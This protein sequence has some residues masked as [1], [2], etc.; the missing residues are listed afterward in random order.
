M[1]TEFDDDQISGDSLPNGRHL[2]DE[3]WDDDEGQAQ[4]IESQLR[5]D[6]DGPSSPQGSLITI[7]SRLLGPPSK[8]RRER[9]LH[10]E[11][12]PDGPER[13]GESLILPPPLEED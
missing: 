8:Q 9:H 1:A 12:A 10:A 5:A 11:L 3:A 6:E 4:W 7:Q 13:S 2:P